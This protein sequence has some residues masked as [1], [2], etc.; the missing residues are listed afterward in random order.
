MT[1]ARL[2]LLT[3]AVAVAL[4]ACGSLQYRENAGHYCRDESRCPY[5][6]R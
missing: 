5:G 6:D 3:L 2:A 4:S 1:R